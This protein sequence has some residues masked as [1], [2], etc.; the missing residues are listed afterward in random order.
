[1]EYRKR[2]QQPELPVVIPPITLRRDQAALAMFP[3]LR[4]LFTSCL[5][6]LQL[7]ALGK[8]FTVHHQRLSHSLFRLQ[9]LVVLTLC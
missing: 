7:Q 5:D 2:V 8:I 4:T 1:M 3:Y 6:G 9:S